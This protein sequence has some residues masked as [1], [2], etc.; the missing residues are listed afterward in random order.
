MDAAVQD[1]IG[2]D[3]LVR[4]LEELVPVMLPG[5]RIESDA[6]P[7]VITRDRSTIEI[8]RGK[9][10]ECWI[11]MRFDD[12]TVLRTSALLTPA[13]VAEIR[14][15]VIGFLCGAPLR[16]FSIWPHQGPKPEL[17]PRRNRRRP[18]LRLASWWSRERRET[19]G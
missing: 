2:F 12:V 10:S 7:M 6:S 3:Y 15:D 4:D 14:A 11:A 17:A 13:T 16:S 9:W 5:V 19:F 8:G 1:S 18:E